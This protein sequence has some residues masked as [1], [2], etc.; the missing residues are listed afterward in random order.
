M[1]VFEGQR[2][3]LVVD[4]ENSA[5][6][7]CPGLLSDRGKFVAKMDTFVLSARDIQ[8]LRRRLEDMEPE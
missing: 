7:L 8:S 2:H 1:T 3:T 5:L 6:V 4:T